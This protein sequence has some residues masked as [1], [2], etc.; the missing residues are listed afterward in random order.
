MK[1]PPRAFVAFDYENDSTIRD[2]LFG[3]FTIAD[4]MFAPVVTLWPFHAPAPRD[5]VPPSWRRLVA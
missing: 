5:A 2:F 1:K 3:Q 4:A